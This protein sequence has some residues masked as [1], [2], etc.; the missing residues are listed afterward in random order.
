MAGGL[1]PADAWQVEHL[2]FTVFGDAAALDPTAAWRGMAGADPEIVTN[3]PKQGVAQVQGKLDDQRRLGLQV[4]PRRIDWVLGPADVEGPPPEGFF[5][6]GALST[7]LENF[8]GLVNRWLPAW[9]GAERLALAGVVHQPQP[10]RVT[11]YKQIQQYLPA[12]SLDPE[13][14]DFLYQINRPRPSQ[15]GIANLRINRLTKWSV[16]FLTHLSGSDLTRLSEVSHRYACR[17]DFDVN[18]AADFR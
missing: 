3:Q 2:R 16:A 11:G 15:T 13:S 8:L 17:L 18:T 9:P 1:P 4:Q 7:A 10:D 14:S 12:I 5:A 6:I